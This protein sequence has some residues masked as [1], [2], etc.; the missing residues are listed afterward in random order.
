MHKLCKVRGEVLFRESNHM[1]KPTREKKN[2]YNLTANMNQVI[3]C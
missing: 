3:S 1:V 2:I